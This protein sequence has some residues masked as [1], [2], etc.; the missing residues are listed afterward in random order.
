MSHLCEQLAIF[1]RSSS[2]PIPLFVDADDFFFFFLV[3]FFAGKTEA[4]R[5]PTTMSFLPGAD[6]SGGDERESAGDERETRGNAMDLFPQR[7]GF[8]DEPRKTSDLKFEL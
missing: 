5:L 7:A 6:V 4:F 3:I 8:G 1:Q 2:G